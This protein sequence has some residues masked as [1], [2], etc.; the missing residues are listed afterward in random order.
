M[1][2]LYQF[3][4]SHYCEKIRWALDYKGLDYKTINLLPGL[5]IK[6]TKRMA[7]Y[8]SVPVLSDEEA[9]I[10]NSHEIITYL[11]ET[12]PQKSLT[13]SDE[14]IRL[15]ALKWEKY[16]D[17][18]LGIHVRVCCYHILLAYPKIVIPFFTHNGPW[19][20]STLIK[21]SYAK[22]NAKMRYFMKINDASFKES[23]VKL[24]EVI[25]K[26]S[27]R[28]QDNEFLVGD[29]FSRAD[30]TAASLLAPLVMPEGYG[31]NWPKTIP[32]ELQILM[33]E[34]KDKI[35]W[36]EEVYKEYR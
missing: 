26:I 33:N 5:H 22:L 14:P 21:L 28:L 10:Q 20:G 9:V 29:R 17:A 19:Y 31:L 18:E 16:L 11:D 34:F 35:A 3:P 27:D 2:K 1:I 8:S 30:L 7:K 36:V 13:P 25:T 24:L 4:I 6:T 15:E 12:Y 32:D 23:K